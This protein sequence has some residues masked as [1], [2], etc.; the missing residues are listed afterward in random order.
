LG[1]RGGAKKKPFMND[2]F[3]MEPAFKEFERVK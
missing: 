1:G 3:E 2:A